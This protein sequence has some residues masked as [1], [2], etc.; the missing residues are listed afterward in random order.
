MSLSPCYDARMFK[1]VM[2]GLRDGLLI[3][4]IAGAAIWAVGIAAVGILVGLIFLFL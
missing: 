2:L 3:G 1:E 4:L